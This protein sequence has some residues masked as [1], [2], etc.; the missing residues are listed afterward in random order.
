MVKGLL[1]KAVTL[2]DVAA[3]A[4]VSTSTAS[5][6]LAGNPAIS[7]AVRQSVLESAQ[8][9]S[10]TAPPRKPRAKSDADLVTVIMPPVG[11]RILPDPFVLELL[12]GITVAMRQRRRNL[13]I[14]HAPP[15][16]EDALNAIF[17]ASPDG[18]FIVLGQSQYHRAL[19]R[20]FH[21]GRSFAVWGPELPDQHY[22]SVGS[23]NIAGGYKI[24]RHLL[25]AGRR[26][27]IFLG[28]APFEVIIDRYSGYQRAL[29]DAGLGV[30]PSLVRTADLGYD[31][32]IDP[33]NDLLDSGIAFDGIVAS[34]DM[35]A[36]GAIAG[37]TR[38]GV[39][40]P[41]DV[42][43]VGYD[44]VALARHATPAL[45]TIRQD[46]VKAGELLVSK[47]LRREAGLSAISER[48]PT[49][50]IVRESCGG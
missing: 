13:I 36:L 7:E 43:V 5:R 29:E 22:C 12:G 32:A 45:T 10:Y 39:R 26:R 2:Q 42:A 31:D 33:I 3:L 1:D 46:V 4:G 8:T 24:T 28:M 27:L 19:N 9:L 48:L 15:A 16:D 14:G 37:L 41:E 21:L 30:D 34:N 6:A 25:R 35:I 20:Q 47:L 11:V 23:D 18:V 44:D 38:R 40:V 17:N 50:M 49:E